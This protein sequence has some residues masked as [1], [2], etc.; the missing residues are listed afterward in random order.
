[1]LY[2]YVFAYCISD[3]A[4]CNPILASSL[5]VACGKPL[6]MDL[7]KVT[8]ANSTHYSFL[9]IGWGLVADIDI[10]S[11]R[12]RMVGGFRFTIWALVRTLCKEYDD[13][14]TVLISFMF[15]SLALRKY[16]GKLSYLP[17]EADNQK[18]DE[19]GAN[20]GV[21]NDD[22]TS[23]FRSRSLNAT[24]EAIKNDRPPV[25]S[26]KKRPPVPP[27][28]EP[29]TDDWVT[30]DGEFVG[31]YSGHQTHMSADCLFAPKA[32]LN[33]G[34]IW[35]LFIKGDATRA[36][37]LQFLAALESGSHVNLPVRCLPLQLPKC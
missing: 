7:I 20:A 27:I 5:N 37:V 8:T 33:D 9:S 32:K 15:S 11:E 2:F 28:T 30:V 12:L 23:C 10:E 4:A 22:S 29:L 13:A 3:R 35:L 14:C 34:I 18:C 19:S 17:V 25:T 16:R 31:V 36:Q 1:M 21:E 6:P 24:H 26:D